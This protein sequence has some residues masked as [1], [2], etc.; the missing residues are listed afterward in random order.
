MVNGK[1]LP[2]ASLAWTNR[3]CERR[4]STGLWGLLWTDGDGIFPIVEGRIWKVSYNGDK[5]N[6]GEPQLAKMAAE[7]TIAHSFSG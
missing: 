7:I 2:T 4:Q 1:Y 5:T 3:K 6:F